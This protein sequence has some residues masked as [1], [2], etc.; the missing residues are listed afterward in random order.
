MLVGKAD[1][2]G[3]SRQW[4]PVNS[5][6][7]RHHPTVVASTARGGRCCEEGGRG[8]KSRQARRGGAEDGTRAGAGH[9]RHAEPEPDRPGRCGGPGA[10]RRGADGT[11]D[12][13]QRQASQGG[14]RGTARR[15]R[16]R[17]TRT[18]GRVRRGRRRPYAGGNT[19]ARTSAP[20]RGRARRGGRGGAGPGRRAGR[21]GPGGGMSRCHAHHPDTPTPRHPH[22]HASPHLKAT[23][24]TTVIPPNQTRPT[25]TRRT[26]A[27]R[28]GGGSDRVRGRDH[29]ETPSDGSRSRRRSRWLPSQCDGGRC[30]LPLHCSYGQHR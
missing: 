15:G 27:R 10:A 28:G 8:P 14:D 6:G 25:R 3:I 18:V 5:K 1:Q 30:R 7:G 17:R 24:P 16:G 22:N 13:Q 11:T 23:H 12:G 26:A 29:A 4:G 9:H 19:S 20:A 2:R 21:G